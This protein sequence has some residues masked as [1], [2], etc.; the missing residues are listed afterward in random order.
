MSLVGFVWQVSNREQQEVVCKI[1]VCDR[2]LYDF[3]K[4]PFYEKELLE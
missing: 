3:R 4:E 2:A 1:I